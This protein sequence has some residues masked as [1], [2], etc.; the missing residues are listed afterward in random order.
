MKRIF[1]LLILLGALAVLGAAYLLITLVINDREPDTPDS[2][3]TPDQIET[4]YT[5][6]RI[7]I[8]S[9]YALKY[10]REGETYSFSLSLDETSWCWLDNKQLPLD[11]TYFAAMA[12]S[13]K[14]VT[15]ELK[16]KVTDSELAAYG[17]DAPWLSVTVSDNVYGTQS[18]S[19]GSLNA[20]MGQYYFLSSA[21]AN[22]VYLVSPDIPSCFGYTP[23][24]MISNDTLPDIAE[25]SISAVHISSPTEDTLYSCHT[26]EGLDAWYVSQSGGAEQAVS[27]E[28]AA[29]LSTLLSEDGA[30]FVSPVGYSE[31]DRSSLGLSEPTTVTITYTETQTVTDQQSGTTTDIAI[32]AQL[33]LLLGYADGEGG[34]YAG[35]PD[36]VL[37][38][39]I[40]STPWESLC[41]MVTKPN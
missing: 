30:R 29:Q 27:T 13:L 12:S 32:D 23:Y 7:D 11:N 38:Y 21:D 2:E 5:A 17:L 16:L 9:M 25:G 3:T 41:T 31:D 6:A 26:D 39:L 40:D 8:S 14:E 18:F 20:F 22:T 4:S 10:S 24:E 34:V 33:V 19:F 37:C 15:A 35:L 1:K 28:L 36:S